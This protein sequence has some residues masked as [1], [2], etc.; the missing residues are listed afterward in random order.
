MIGRSGLLEDIEESHGQHGIITVDLKSACG[1][2]PV[3]LGLDD[4]SLT[5]TLLLHDTRE[6]STARLQEIRGGGNLNNR[7]SYRAG[8][9]KV[10]QLG[11]DPHSPTRS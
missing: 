6:V 4:H 8:K 1:L 11:R 5:L 9:L 7:E 3:H 10:H 2:G